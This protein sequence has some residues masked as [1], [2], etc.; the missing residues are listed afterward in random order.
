MSKQYT[1]PKPNEP[2]Q[3]ASDFFSAIEKKM[4]YLY[5]RWQDEKEYEDIKDYQ[6]PLNPIA[7]QFGVTIT[8]MNKRPFGFIFKVDGRT[9]KVT[10]NSRSLAFERTA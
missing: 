3:R 2:S 7:E 10:M 8:K 1:V 5:G 4:A 9:Y 6:L